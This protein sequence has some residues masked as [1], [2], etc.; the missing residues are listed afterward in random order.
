MIM[1][2]DRS[3][4][5]YRQR[6]LIFLA[7]YVLGFT[8]GAWLCTST[9]DNTTFAWL[10]LHTGIDDRVWLAIAVAASLGGWALR[11]VGAAYL[12]DR[13]VQHRDAQAETLCVSGPFRFVRNPLYLGNIILAL[14]I[15]AFAPVCGL[16]LLLLGTTGFAWI[17]A[18]Y[19][20]HVMR[21]RFG[22]A[23]CSY[24]RSVPAL[25]PR[26]T[27]VAALGPETTPSFRSGM[28]SELLTA[29][30]AAATIIAC[31]APERAPLI[32]AVGWLAGVATRIGVSGSR[33]AP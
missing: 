15:G 26:I 28:R 27:A 33:S 29:A 12:R 5:W 30:L 16:G 18:T 13:V 22:E 10:G 1:T 7:F 25:V 4:W 11:L 24:E 9:D 19:E 31:F 8:A 23:Y 21:A 6:G 32:F 17:L 2:G 14:G 20:T 3:P